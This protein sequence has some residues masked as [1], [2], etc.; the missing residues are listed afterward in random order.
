MCTKLRRLY[1]R[2]SKGERAYALTGVP[3]W[4]SFTIYV[5]IGVPIL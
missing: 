2:L 4:L 5:L 1:R 3:L